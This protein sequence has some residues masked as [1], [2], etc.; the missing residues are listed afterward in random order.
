MREKLFNYPHIYALKRQWHSHFFT[1]YEHKI[2]LKDNRCGNFI[3]G[4]GLKASVAS[5]LLNIRADTKALYY[6]PNKA[7]LHTD[8][9]IYRCARR[10]RQNCSFENILCNFIHTFEWFND[11]GFSC[12]YRHRLFAVNGV[13]VRNF[14]IP[15]ISL[16]PHE[17]TASLGE[18]SPVP[19]DAEKFS[20]ASRF[21]SPDSS[22]RL[23]WFI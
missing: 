10:A 11:S 15:K 17:G 23:L 12:S 1:V 9:Q 20:Q 7:V 16:G 3:E 8:Q 22:Y 18:S 2:W 6:V 5:Y 14:F 4:R 13:F 21:W 19:G